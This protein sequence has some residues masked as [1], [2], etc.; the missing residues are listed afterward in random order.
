MFMEYIL[1]KA[2]I[3]IGAF[4]VLL[5]TYNML[6]ISHN[7]SNYECEVSTLTR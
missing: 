3:R 2:P 5:Y 1:K 4:L 7:R 6:S